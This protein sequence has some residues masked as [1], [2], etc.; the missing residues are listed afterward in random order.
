MNTA[1]LN[2]IEESLSRHQQNR[3]ELIS[4]LQEIQEKLGY[5]PM[6]ALERVARGLRL[7]SS[8]VQGVASFYAQF[9]FVPSGRTVVKVCKGT[10][11]HVRGSPRVLTQVQKL[12]GI[13]PGETSEDLEYSLESVACFG[14]CALAPVMVVNNKVY[15]RMTPAKAVAILGSGNLKEK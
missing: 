15:G 12:I 2:I 8:K 3:K 1:D 7:P 4:I 14:S 10:A 5:L 6:E 9:K 13:N 11:C